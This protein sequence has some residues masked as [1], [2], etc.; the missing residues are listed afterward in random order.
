MSE[1]HPLAGKHILLVDD[2]TDVLETLEDL[3]YMC[4]LEAASSFEE[5]RDKLEMHYFDIAILD[6]M[7]VQGYDLLKL[8]SEKDVLC[9]MLTANAMT[10]QDIERSY[11]EGAASFLPKEKMGDID[12]FL[13]DILEA[14]KRGK[15]V[16]WRWFDRL[17]DYFENKF[18]PDWQN[19]HGITVK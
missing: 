14:K 4:H 10:P 7:G 15:S 17:A 8:A 18:G 11:Q 19:K 3:L 13:N 12:V 2:E 9:V 5:A 1:I 6:I 16:W